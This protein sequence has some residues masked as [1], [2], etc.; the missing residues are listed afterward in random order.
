MKKIYNDY[1]FVY[2]F[3]KRYKVSFLTT[4]NQDHEPI[5]LEIGQYNICIFF[6]RK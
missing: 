6:L 1:G 2:D 3:G 4:A 5:F